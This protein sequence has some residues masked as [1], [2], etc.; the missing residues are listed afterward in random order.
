MS[1]TQVAKAVYHILK[2]DLAIAAAVGQK[3][4]PVNVPQNT[5]SPFIS[6]FVVSTTPVDTKD[7]PSQIDEVRV[8]ID[9]W[10]R[11]YG[12]AE[13]IHGIVRTALDAYPIGTLVNGIFLD[14][15][16]YDTERDDMEEET[17]LYRRSADYMIR[18]K[19]IEN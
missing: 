19:Y 10:A 16:R 6:F 13:D 5:A 4:Y 9:V 7:R 18:V 3:I 2:T 14:G 1:R 17:D 12:Q 15:I 11:T 8:Q